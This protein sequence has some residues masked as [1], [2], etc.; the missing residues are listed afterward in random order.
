MIAN[1]TSPPLGV[2][3]YVTEMDAVSVAV[4]EVP[5]TTRLTAASD[6]T[7]QR[8]RMCANGRP[9]CV[10]CL[11]HEFASRE[12]DLRLVDYSALPVAGATSADLDPVERQRLRRAIEAHHGDPYLVGLDDESLDGALGLVR[13]EASGFVPTV[14]GLLLIGRET[15]LRQHL[16]THEVAFQVIE[17]TDV[18]VNDFHR[19]PLVRLFDEVER[20]FAARITTR[21]LSVGLFRV[22]VPTMDPRA[23]REAFVNAL[24][25]RDLARMGAI[26]VKMT[27]EAVIVSN[28]GGFVEGVNPENILSVEPRPRN[29]LLADI[30]KRIGLAE[31]TGRGVDIIYSGLLRFGR[32]APDFSRS[33]GQS[34]VVDMSCREADMQFL[35]FIV[36]NERAS[37]PLPVEHLIILSRLREFKRLDL[38]TIARAIQRN[39]ATARRH[40]EDLVETGL[41]QPHGGKPDRTYTL[42]PSV[43]RHLGA[44][45]EYVRKAGFDTIQQ[46]QMVL[47]YLK[48]HGSMA[49]RDVMNL[50]RIGVPETR[51]LVERLK[52]QGTI[53]IEGN[54][55]TARY[56]LA[57][58]V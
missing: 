53:V 46:E 15:A 4:I 9:E 14:A 12:S 35:E 28:P 33:D 32:P 44:G 54:R 56:K 13:S 5:R 57:K 31:R 48:E 36:T 43:Y 11:P 40:V 27:D 19:W 41:V 7:I 58:P 29:P 23:F 49:R 2:R 17:G 45:S 52:H 24:T 42:A 18:R 55:R 20:Q 8:R 6:G 1:R 25:H 21:E 16:P 51:R 34:V 26:H 38:D 50:C 10:P 47:R 30:F 22:D 37:G 3:V 39:Q